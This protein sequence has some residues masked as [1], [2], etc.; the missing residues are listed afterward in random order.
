MVQLPHLHEGLVEWSTEALSPC[1]TTQ[2]N[3]P[4]HLWGWFGSARLHHFTHLPHFHKGVNPKMQIH[5]ILYHQQQTQHAVTCHGKNTSAHMSAQLCLPTRGI[6]HTP[7]HAQV[8]QGFPTRHG[9]MV[10][11]PHFNKGSMKICTS[12][13][14]SLSTCTLL[15]FKAGYSQAKLV[16]M[17][18]QAWHLGPTPPLAWRVA[19]RKD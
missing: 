10:R 14:L 1:K 3:S 6:K 9:T 7:E 11:L 12:T 15:I 4:M 5:G 17:S 19:W 8:Q 2:S 16:D 18:N 13:T